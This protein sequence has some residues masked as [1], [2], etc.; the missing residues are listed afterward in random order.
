MKASIHFPYNVSHLANVALQSVRTDSDA[1]H[2]MFFSSTIGS[3]DGK[4][5]SEVIG[6][7]YIGHANQLLELLKTQ[8]IKMITLINQCAVRNVISKIMSK[9][10]WVPFEGIAVICIIDSVCSSLALMLIE[11]M[12]KF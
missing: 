5:P 3:Y 12:R 4:L 8:E 6:N 10:E 2:R 1:I 11:L 7:A 9:L